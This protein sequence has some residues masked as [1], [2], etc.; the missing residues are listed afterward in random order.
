MVLQSSLAIG[1]TGIGTKKPDE[2]SVLDI[3]SK[4]KGLLIPR[5]S[6]DERDLIKNPANALIIFNT[7]KMA[8]EVN[9]GTKSNSIWTVVGNNETAKNPFA[10]ISTGALW[11]GDANGIAKEVLVSGEMSFSDTGRAVIFNDAVIS[12]TLTGYKAGSGKISANDNIIEAI[13]KLDGRIW[14]NKTITVSDNYIT[15]LTDETL[16]CDTESKSF[17]ITLPEPSTSKGK[18][19]VIKK[20]DETSNK[21]LLQPPVYISKENTISQLNYTKS[22]KIQSD[23]K[24]W[25]IIN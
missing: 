14:T 22:F 3:D 18:V 9:I 23:G 5:M 6:S 19:Y 11:V 2:S 1:Q 13:Q 10:N 8:I 17:T 7:T 20:T 25:N 16:L 21:L 12:K 24:V 15:L 4:G